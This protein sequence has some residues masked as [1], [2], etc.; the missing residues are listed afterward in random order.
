MEEWFDKW[1]NNKEG[2]KRSIAHFIGKSGIG[3]KTFIKSLIEKNNIAQI[4]INCLYDKS[5][6]SMNKRTFVQE[7]KYLM[8][9]RGIEYFLHK[10]PKLII[11]HNMHILRDKKFL[12]DIFDLT[13][14]NNVLSPILCIFNKDFISERLQSH[15]SK[16]CDIF[17]MEAHNTYYLKEIIRKK[18]IE[19]NFDIS[20]KNIHNLSYSCDGNIH[21]LLLHWKEHIICKSLLFNN[22]ENN[23]IEQDESMNVIEKSFRILCNKNIHWNDKMDVVKTNGSLLKLLMSTHVFGGLDKDDS[24]TFSE[25]INISLDCMKHLSKGETLSSSSSTRDLLLF[26]QW[27]YPTYKVQ[28]ITIKTMTLPNFPSTTNLPITRL[29]PFPPEDI[30][31]I[32][33]YFIELFSK[34][35]KNDK[36]C[37]KNIIKY[38]PNFTKDLAYEL[39]TTHFKIF[40]RK[41]ITKKG[42]NRFFKNLH[43]EIL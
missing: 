32:A 1:F 5:H 7:L 28:I 36:I 14:N 11:I 21:L 16:K 22:I 29:L 33:H 43:P 18:S 13:E 23:S 25:K 10:K 39:N 9:H 15:I 20:E 6:Y 2:N 42:I 17:F 35:L 12:D 24:K 31:Y 38:Y 30:L 19:I 34:N 37:S 4:D 8:T 27:F 26:L 3:K 41:D 40:P